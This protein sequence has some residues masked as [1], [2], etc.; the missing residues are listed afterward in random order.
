[1]YS[2]E[3]QY[4]TTTNECLPTNEVMF[5]IEN[6]FKEQPFVIGTGI[7]RSA[8][9]LEYREGLMIMYVNLDNS[10]YTMIIHFPA[11]DMSCILISGEQFQPAPDS[12]E[13]I[14]L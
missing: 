7:V 5:E 3:V 4:F 12:G 8:Y 13:E 2:A 11:D 14:S 6:R 9:D 10:T 1:V